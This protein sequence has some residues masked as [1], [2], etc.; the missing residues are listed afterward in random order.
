MW[1]SNQHDYILRII[2][3]TPPTK[4]EISK[5]QRKELS[6]WQDGPSNEA[7]DAESLWMAVIAQAIADAVS[8]CRKLKSEYYKRAALKW[9][10]GDGED[11]A[12][13]CIRAGL[14]P[15]IVR[16][17]AK[18]A[19]LHPGTWRTAPGESARYIERRGKRLRARQEC[20][21]ERIEQKPPMGCIIYHLFSE[22]KTPMTD[23]KRTT[24]TQIFTR[25]CFHGGLEP[26]AHMPAR[27]R[28]VASLLMYPEDLICAAY[29]H[30]AR[31]MQPGQLPREE[32]FIMFMQP[33]F[34]HRQKNDPRR[35]AGSH[36]DDDRTEEL[37][38][39]GDEA[40]PFGGGKP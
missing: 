16:M 13:V 9:L 6:R 23:D 11:F 3:Y 29:H 25:L 18:H 30:I 34:M 1:P 31:H 20:F 5:K 28:F 17:K 24:L 37:V 4:P 40:P 10:L 12:D 36:V 2:Q 33:E 35:M 14:E 21:A 15:A 32:D 39:V 22:E 26:Q 19:I 38:G 27:E 8:N 7:I